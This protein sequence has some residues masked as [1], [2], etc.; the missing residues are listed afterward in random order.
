[1]NS[2]SSV[3]SDVFIILS[4]RV[5]AGWLFDQTQGYRAAILIA[6]GGNIL[7]VYVAAG[8]PQRVV[9]SART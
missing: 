3:K 5:F 7:G 6:A 9:G 4:I 8:L 2:R 1:M